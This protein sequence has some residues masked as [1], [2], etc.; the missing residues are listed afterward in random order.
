MRSQIVCESG[1]RISALIAL[2]LLL[3]C[4]R[5]DE[6]ITAAATEASTD[7]SARKGFFGISLTPLELL[8]EQGAATVAEVFAADE[9]LEWQLYVPAIYDAN[10]PAGAI[11][12]I[13]PYAKGGPP[14]SWHDVMR[15]N[16]MIWIGARNAGNEVPATK[17]MFLAMFA[18]M[19]LQRRYA[20]N[21]ERLYLAGFSGGGKTASRVAVLRPNMF[22]GGIFISGALFWGRNAPP[23]LNDV[24]QL[25]YVFI[26][27][28]NDFALKETKVVQRKFL[29]AGVDK[30]QLIVIRNH[31]HRLPDVTNM[32][33]AIAYLDSRVAE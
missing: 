7:V 8:G 11:V 13:S 1:M 22:K 4:A 27:G 19:V 25:H 16:N 9:V 29:A 3:V 18:P 10:R 21:A 15:D 28:T 32:N 2:C 30:S 14:K 6:D 26:S 20:L 5:A 12:Y 23:L 33:R 17:R 31:G 24:S